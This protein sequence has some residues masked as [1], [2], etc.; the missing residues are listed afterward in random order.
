MTPVLWV[1]LIGG[2]LVATIL[3][4][5]LWSVRHLDPIDSDEWPLRKDDK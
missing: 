1:A 2:S 4:A 5:L 3:A